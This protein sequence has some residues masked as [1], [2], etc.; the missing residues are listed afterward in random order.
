MSETLVRT[1]RPAEDIALGAE[2]ARMS[3]NLI[4]VA[5]VTK[6]LNAAGVKYV[7]VGAHAA[8]GYTAAPRNTQDVEILARHP[9]QA[10]D[11][12]AKAFPHLTPVDTPVVV[13]FKQPDGEVAIDIM[14][15]GSPP[16][17]RELIK[18]AREV[19]VEGVP[20]PIPPVEGMLAAKL[21]AMTSP[22]RPSEKKMFDGGDFIAIVKANPKLDLAFLERLGE[23]VYN[24]G[25]KEILKLVNDAQEGRQ[26]VL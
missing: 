26:I 3:R 6:A 19:V 11:V 13:R 1:P 18:I 7:L 14:K 17:W 15:P 25:G 21:A 16:L 12:I 4:G 23:L 9:K 2:L 8:N 10:C 20:V 5:E 22:L 24:G